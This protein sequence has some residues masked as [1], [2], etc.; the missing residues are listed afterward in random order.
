[1][2]GSSGRQE[3]RTKIVTERE[4]E[5][6]ASLGATNDSAQCWPLVGKVM[7]GREMPLRSK[8]SGLKNGSCQ[9]VVGQALTPSTQ[10]ADA[11]GSL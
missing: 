1:M 10:E 7:A 2:L 9:A 4:D 8:G 3:R 11:G 6:R 5:I